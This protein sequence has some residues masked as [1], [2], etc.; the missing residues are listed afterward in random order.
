VDV[1]TATPT[2]TA[3]ARGY[4]ASGFYDEAFDAAGDARA[5]YD[6]VLASLEDADL[7]GLSARVNAD[8]CARATTFTV[9]G[10]TQQ[11]PLDPVPR[12]IGVA[13]WDRLCRGLEQRARALNAF[14]ADVY[15][16]RRIVEAGIVPARTIDGCEHFEPW[17]LGV[18]VPWG[19]A[20][21]AGYDVVRG[22]DGRLRILEDNTRTPSG[23]AYASAARRVVDAH[24]PRAA[25]PL[26]RDFDDCYDLLADALRA[27][28]PDGRGDPSIAMLS[29]G[30]S[31]SAW[32]EHR[33]IARRLGISICEPA[34]L[35]PRNGRLH[36]AL[37]SGR[38][39]ELQVLYRRTDQDRLSDGRG[40]ATWLTEALLSP[41]RRGTLA[42]VNTPGSGVADDK[43]VHAYVEDMIRFYL[44]EDPLVESVRT[45]DLGEPSERV[46]ALGRLQALVVKPRAGH[47][48]RGVVIGP[49]ATPAE[50][51]LAAAAIRARPEDFVAQETIDLSRHPTICD[52]R[53][54]PRHVDLRVFSIASGASVNVVPG[55]LT[56]VAL[57]RGSLIVNS[58]RN[59]GGKD[60]WVLA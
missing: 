29:D 53:L 21:V 18:E 34:D 30:P 40:G 46:R 47:G 14:V 23:M 4:D 58:S 31:N 37:P 52:G 59:G 60:T 12:I 22:A 55:G 48:G 16:G 3:R 27:A 50:R 39:R 35:R 44:G 42:I 6:A 11:F 19:H 28:A 17:M 8:P 1:A 13:E 7:R 43:L 32:Y 49:H 2:R 33:A 54:E 56:R 20:T 51:E 26:R 45:Y 24:L 57:E 9:A 15:G 5:A 41:L 25:R 10:R 36:L 38:L